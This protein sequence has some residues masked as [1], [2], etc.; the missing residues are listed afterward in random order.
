[1]SALRFP[2]QNP[3]HLLYAHFQCRADV[4]HGIKSDVHLPGFNQAHIRLGHINLHTQLFLGHSQRISA[5]ADGQPKFF[6]NVH[7][8]LFA[9][10]GP[11]TIRYIEYYVIYRMLHE[12]DHFPAHPTAGGEQ[13]PSSSRGGFRGRSLGGAA[14]YPQPH[15]PLFCALFAFP[16][17]LRLHVRSRAAPRLRAKL[18]LPRREVRFSN[19]ISRG[20][21]RLRGSRNKRAK[22]LCHCVSGR[23]GGCLGG[24]ANKYLSK[25]GK[26]DVLAETNKATQGSEILQFDLAWN[27]PPTRQQKQTRQAFVPLRQRTTRRM[28]WRKSK[29]IFEQK[30]QAGCAGGNQQSHAGK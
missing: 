30:R 1:M 9:D 18:A 27:F 21:S 29:Q 19:S 8:A 24:K 10:S 23:Q 6:L 5:I 12:G 14:L 7:T 28:P 25:N 4:F 17:R 3:E 22:R 26:P 11:D 16:Y 2:S 13:D 15:L 20:A